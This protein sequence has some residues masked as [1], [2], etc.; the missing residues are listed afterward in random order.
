M[1][2]HIMNKK[3]ITKQLHAHKV[4]FMTRNIL[5]EMLQVNVGLYQ[6]TT[7]QNNTPN[8]NEEIHV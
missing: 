8:K 4:E 3:N 7:I 6:G 1:K 2:V 5:Q